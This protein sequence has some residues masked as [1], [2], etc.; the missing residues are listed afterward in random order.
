MH[1]GGR[2][3]QVHLRAF[4]L[5]AVLLRL[6]RAK[7]QP[8]RAFLPSLGAAPHYGMKRRPAHAA[9]QPTTPTNAGSMTKAN[10]SN[11]FTTAS[12][13]ASSHA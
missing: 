4:V 10:H 5:T 7:Y 3:S 13:V 6:A 12:E 1:S 8:L 2:G 11:S 9:A